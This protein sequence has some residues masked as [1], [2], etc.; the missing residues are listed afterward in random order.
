MMQYLLVC[1]A[2]FGYI[3]EIAHFFD[4]PEEMEQVAASWLAGYSTMELPMSEAAA[5]KM[6]PGR[7]I[8]TYRR[9]AGGFF[10]LWQGEP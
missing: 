6:R 2:R 4:T 9:G 10:E 5:E 1:T 3:T 8:E 7:K